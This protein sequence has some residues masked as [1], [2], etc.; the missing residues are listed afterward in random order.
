MSPAAAL[1]ALLSVLGSG[2]A[3]GE[4]WYDGQAELSGYRWRGTRYGEPRTGE[5]VAIFVTEPFSAAQHVK[6][7]RPAEHTGEVVTVLKLNLVR[8]FQTGIYDY[9]TMSSCFVDVERFGALKLSF[10]SSEWCGNVYE[11]LDV[12]A[13]G[14][15]LS[16]HSYFQGE[17]VT[18]T[19]PARA[20]AL[21]GD[22]LFVWLRGL[23]ALPLAAGETRTFPYLPDAFERRLRHREAGWTELEVARVA[24]PVALV[25]PAGS[26][27]AIEYRLTSGDG[28]TGRVEV[29]QAYPHRLL[30]W[31]WARGEELLDAGE[32]TGSKRLKYW[33]LQRQG[34]EALRAELGL[35]VPAAR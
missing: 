32:L 25:L 33:E 30:A 2:D 16:V 17:S 13:D 24:E 21:L 7:D 11:E 4:H 15:A 20:D 27:S 1:L 14:L 34:Q 10:S 8:D 35:S 9:D 18:K 3:F 5:A 26:F 22:Q 19:L 6:V 23:R 29:D 31:R 28:R 12:R